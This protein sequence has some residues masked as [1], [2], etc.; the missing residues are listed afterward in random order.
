MTECKGTPCRLVGRY[1]LACTMAALFSYFRWAAC[2]LMLGACSPETPQTHS[3]GLPLTVRN[4]DLEVRI[5]ECQQRTSVGKRTDLFDVLS[6]DYAVKISV[7]SR[8][9]TPVYVLLVDSLLCDHGIDAYRGKGDK[10]WRDVNILDGLDVLVR[11]GRRNNTL[12]GKTLLPRTIEPVIFYVAYPS[13]KEKYH[14]SSQIPWPF[15]SLRLGLSYTVKN[16]KGY[17]RHLPFAIVAFDSTNRQHF[18]PPRELT[19]H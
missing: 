2:L 8:S 15:D 19:L 14:G 18:L 16:D 9:D 12:R 11:D 1:S 3:N 5:L 6:Y 4:Q 10:E 7:R 13:F 17:G